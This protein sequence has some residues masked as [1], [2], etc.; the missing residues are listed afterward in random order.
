MVYLRMLKLEGC[1]KLK[2]TICNTSADSASPN[3]PP[4]RPP[5]LEWRGVALVQSAPEF[6][7]TKVCLSFLTA[8]GCAVILCL[9][10]WR[11]LLH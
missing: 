6:D 10:S 9:T 8:P 11:D 3:C 2:V 5:A 4:A 1:T 7:H